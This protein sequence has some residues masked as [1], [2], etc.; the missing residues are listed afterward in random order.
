MFEETK[1]HVAVWWTE[2]LFAHRRWISIGVAAGVYK[3]RSP[4]FGF[5]NPLLLIT[6]LLKHPS[7]SHSRN[8]STNLLQN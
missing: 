3:E 8:Y 1:A 2:A 5:D 6:C 4:G 7:R